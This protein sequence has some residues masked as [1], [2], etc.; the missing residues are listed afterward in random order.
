MARY[1][2]G[3]FGMARRRSLCLRAPN[4]KLVR[5]GSGCPRK[6]QTVPV[7]SLAAIPDDASFDRLI[8]IS[9]L[10]GEAFRKLVGKLI[11][12]DIV[13][14]FGRLRGALARAMPAATFSIA[15]VDRSGGTGRRHHSSVGTILGS[16]GP[17][18]AR[19]SQRR[20]PKG[21][22]RSPLT[23]GPTNSA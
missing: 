2:D 8:V 20:R 11:A 19:P 23:F 15:A 13:T 1:R 7:F 18:I 5:F 3:E 9:W 17:K 21:P 12:A 10:G 16:L 22:Q 4:T 6:N 14:L